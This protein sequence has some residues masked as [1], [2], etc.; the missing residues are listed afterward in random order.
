MTRTQQVAIIKRKFMHLSGE[1]NERSRR[2]W[3]AAEAEAIGSGGIRVVCE[4]TGMD[5]KTV[6]AGLREIARE[7]DAAVPGRIR[8][9]GGGRKK[10]T[11]KDSGLKQALNALVEPT[12]RGDPECPLRW[13]TKSTTDLAEA[14]TSQGHSI[15]YHTVHRLLTGGGYSLQS[16]RKTHEGTHHPDRDQQFQCISEETRQFQTKNQPVISVDTKKKG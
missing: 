13:T 2:Y 1:L 14:L 4:A 5:H 9:P 15:S 3:A 7:A 10:L 6:Q 11:E 8:R 16:N 12:E